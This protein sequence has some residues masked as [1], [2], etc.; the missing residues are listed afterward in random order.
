MWDRQRPQSLSSWPSSCGRGLRARVT[1][2]ESTQAGE[3]VNVMRR[4]GSADDAGPENLDG[5]NAEAVPR[6]DLRGWVVPDD[7]H[8]AWIEPVLRQDLGKIWPLSVRPGSS[9]AST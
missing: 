1:P 4:G 3:A 7:Q 9:I 8:A 5:R 2:D 6:V